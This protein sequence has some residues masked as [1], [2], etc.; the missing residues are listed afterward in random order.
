[1]KFHTP[2]QSDE[3]VYDKLTNQWYDS[4]A[5]DGKY[6]LTRLRKL[7]PQDLKGLSSSELRLMRNEI[8]ARHGYLF[9]SADINR[10]FMSQSWY[11]PRSNNSAVL[12]ELSAI[13]RYNIEFIRG[14]E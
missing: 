11:I 14:Y 6:P 8:Y 7:V 3:R 2:L 9:V 5:D 13:E 1:M 4:R 10:Y 12:K